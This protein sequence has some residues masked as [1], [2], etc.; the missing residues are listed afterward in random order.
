MAVGSMTRL[1]SSQQSSGSYKVFIVEDHPVFRQGLAQLIREQ[2]NF[3]V[4]G[5]IAA[6]ENA[7]PAIKRAMPD[8]V[9]VDITLPGKSGLDLIRQLQAFP[10]IKILVVSMHDEAL[11]ANRVLRAGAHGY[12][13][14]QEDPQEIV[15]ALGDVLAGKIYVGEEVLESAR[16]KKPAKSAPRLL[17]AL[18]DLELE[19][20]EALGRGKTR[21]KVAKELRLSERSVTTQHS[22]IRRKLGLR[23]SRDLVR[24]AICWVETGQP[25]QPS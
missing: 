16:K 17:E 20:L 9:L 4:C 7:L 19:V 2:P 15:A 10:Q 12:V 18:S 13:M 11:Y 23:T 5:E 24:Y 1:T 14:K 3:T 21:R 8:A 6:A 25:P 22:R